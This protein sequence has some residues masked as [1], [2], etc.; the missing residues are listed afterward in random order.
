MIVEH[1]LNRKGHDVITTEPGR[2][3]AETAR[4]LDDKRIGAM[5]VSDADHP[6][7]GI[8][9]ERDIARAV[10]RRG[11]AALDEPVSQHMTAKVITCTRRSMVSHLMELMTD[12]RLRHVPVV[13]SGRLLHLDW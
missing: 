3:L 10:A 11:A 13:E 9:S 12:R 1:I 8:I 5:V 2:S 6:V 7:L 4:L